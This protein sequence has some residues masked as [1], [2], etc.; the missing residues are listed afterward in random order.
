V[1][2]PWS[3]IW[4]RRTQH[5]RGLDAGVEGEQGG[6]PAQGAVGPLLVVVAAEVV[7]LE[8]KVG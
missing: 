5:G 6:A 3:S 1:T 8:L 2:L 7:E 4:S